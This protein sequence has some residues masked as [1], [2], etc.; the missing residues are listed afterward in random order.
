MCGR[1]KRDIYRG[2][3][4]RSGFVIRVNGK[5]KERIIS[6]VVEMKSRYSY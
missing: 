4:K 2:V 6:F 5:I 1:E 3:R